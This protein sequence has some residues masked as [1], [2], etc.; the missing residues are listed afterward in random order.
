MNKKTQKLFLEVIK[1]Q[2]VEEKIYCPKCLEKDGLQV[3]LKEMD[4]PQCHRSYVILQNK[5]V[6]KGNDKYEFDICKECG[7]RLI[8]RSYMVPD[9]PDDVAWDF[10]FWCE[11]DACPSNKVIN[12]NS[13]LKFIK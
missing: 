12:A 6:S 8:I 2:P 11:N 9:G 7:G 4:C 3:E 1:N 5:L 13:F 10:D